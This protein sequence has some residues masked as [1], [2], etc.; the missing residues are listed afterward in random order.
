MSDTQRP[1]VSLLMPICNVEKYLEQCLASAC[2]QT[3]RDLEIICINDGST[4]GSLAI[5]Q[6]FAARDERIRI[7][8]KP[9]SGYGDSMNRGLETARGRYVAILES[10]DFLDP[11][12]LE[13]MAERC[14]RERLDLLKCNF[15]LYW[16]NPGAEQLNRHNLYFSAVS[17]EM[18]L[19]GV[20]RAVD[21]PEIFWAKAS[22]WSVMYRRAFLEEN[23]VRFLPTPGASFQDTSFSFKAFACAERVAYSCRAFLHYRQDNEKSSVNNPGKV[24]C[25]CDEHDE[26]SRF[27][28]E[29]RADLKPE[30]DA[31]RAK[32]KFYNYRWNLYRLAPELRG[33][34]LE[35]FSREMREEVEAGNVN[36]VEGDAAR[37]AFNQGEFDEIHLIAYDPEFYSVKFACENTSKLGTMMQ[38]AKSG[39]PSYVARVIKDKVSG[40]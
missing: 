28:N 8:D 33:E 7:I 20:H 13:Y 11:E 6:S 31:I 17:P 27:L 10:D 24:F 37:Y 30:L 40:R 22:I 9:N 3:L 35:R 1:L 32:M 18:E 4:D 36:V 26:I 34:F 23:N 25:V 15:Y 19:M 21:V 29:D 12:A 2:A 16:S 38:Y 39:G 5:I 14:E